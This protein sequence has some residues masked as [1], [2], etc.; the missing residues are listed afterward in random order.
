M[1]YLITLWVILFIPWELL[2]S[3]LWMRKQAQRGQITFPK[4]VSCKGQGQ[5]ST[6]VSLNP[7]PY[8]IVL[9]VSRSL[10]I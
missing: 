6:L 10:G 5:T 9:L 4:S 1:H 3:H 2:L 7:D 8:A